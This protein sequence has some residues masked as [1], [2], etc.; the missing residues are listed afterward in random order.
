MILNEHNILPRPRILIQNGHMI[1]EAGQDKNIT[2]KTKGAGTLNFLGDTQGGAR[3][4]GSSFVFPGLGGGGQN[5]Q[6]I[7]ERLSNL[8]DVV[9]TEPGLAVRLRNMD[10]NIQQLMV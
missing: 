3:A 9:N 7:L 2:F 10:T 1:L 5:Q 6:Q 4:A 8:E